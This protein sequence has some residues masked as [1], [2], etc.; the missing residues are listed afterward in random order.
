M[1]CLRTARTRAILQVAREVGCSQ[2]GVAPASAPAHWDALRGALAAGWHAEMAWL[3]RADTLAK[4]ADPRLLLPGARSLV[5]VAWP[6]E[7]TGALDGIAGYARTEDYHDTLRRVLAPVVAMIEAQGGT[8][9]L[10]ID[11]APLC[12]VAHAARA[13]LGWVGKHTLLLRREGGSWCHLAGI[14]TDLEL[15]CDEPATEHC[16]RC[17]RCLDACPTGALVQPYGL[18]A[19]RCL[20][21]LTIE[22]RGE[23]DDALKPAIDG[24][25]FGCDVCQQV[26]PWTRTASTAPTREALEALLALDEQ[27]FQERFAGTPV[28]RTK[29]RGL[30]RNVCLALGNL[31]EPA[32]VPALLAAARD[33]EPVVRDA[34]T[35]ALAALRPESL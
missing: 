13:G 28:L 17:T 20:S 18:D 8:A 11:S 12:E 15:D 7:P 10:C 29:R 1:D 35:W 21:Y 2:V 14:V 3:E 27:G 16:G 4:R 33:S 22:H 9:R 31:G 23:V 19:R 6:I 24:W 26:C 25:V 5:M 30:R 34:A 32:A